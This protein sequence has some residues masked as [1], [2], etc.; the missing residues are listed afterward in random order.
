MDI[1]AFGNLTTQAGQQIKFE[2]FDKNGDGKVSEEE[3]NTALKE[4][5]LDAV[6]LSKVDT[7]GDKTVSNEE[8]QVWEQKIKMEEALAPY[9]QQV[10]T[11]FIGANSTY[12]ADMTAALRELIDKF[13]EEYT[14][15]G[16]LVSNM[17][18]EFEAALPAKYEELKTGILE[19]TPEALAQ[20]EAQEKADIVSGVL[21]EMLE[22]LKSQATS[23]STATGEPEMN[24]TAAGEYVK[25][26]GALL[27]KEAN[28]FIAEYT[29]SNLE[30]ALKS[31]LREFLNTTDKGK[32]TNEISN[33]ERNS[34]SFGEYID[35]NELKQLKEEAK[36]LLKAALEQGL[37]ITLD[38]YQYT[39]AAALEQKINSYTDGSQLKAAVDKFIEELSTDSVSEAA[40]AKAI[41]AAEAAEQKAFAALKGEDLAINA[42]IIDYSDIP[43]YYD[44]TQ[45]HERGKGWSGSLEKMQETVSN[46]LNNESL[47]TQLMNQIKSNLESK[48][49]SFDMIEVIFNNVY[50]QSVTDTLST[51]GLIT[52]RGARG[53]SK[54][55]HAYCNTADA[56]NTFINIFNTNMTTA[57]NEMN[58]SS[59]D[60]DVQDIDYTQ[61]A[62][63]AKVR[64]EVKDALDKNDNYTIGSWCNLNEYLVEVAESLIDALKSQMLR[65][66]VSM[67][68]ANNIEFDQAVFDAMFTNARGL[69]VSKNVT[70]EIEHEFFGIK[71]YKSTFNPNTLMTSFVNDFRTEYSAWVESQK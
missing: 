69:T 28:A 51:E 39:N 70:T 2:D 58:A 27:E 66:A 41:T 47:K 3:Y 26:L 45:L 7:N 67:C 50:K 15:Q 29:G 44:N 52:G 40:K 48:G 21:D 59:T 22:E 12:A 35:A 31:H 64:D 62:E 36:E 54:K 34:S 37:T 17:A 4:Y 30:A 65:K 23:K 43:G 16:N 9:I 8:F 20:R 6:E 57:I 1:R 18:Q 60:M 10:T 19:N 61:A 11:D 49:I 33:W 56:V 68:N 38:G 14:N 55:G 5:D 42:S 63:D 24:D 32:I 25:T 46:L 71:Y 53:M 13:A